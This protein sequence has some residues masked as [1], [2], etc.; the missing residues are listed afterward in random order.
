MPNAIGPS[1][2]GLC[3]RLRSQPNEVRGTPKV[4]WEEAAE[5]LG[6][7]YPNGMVHAIDEI[8]TQRLTRYCCH[9]GGRCNSFLG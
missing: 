2:R 8:Y 6:M 1:L 3:P 7:A 5:C 4:C 9:E